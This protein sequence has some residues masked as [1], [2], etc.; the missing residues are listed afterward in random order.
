MVL[1]EISGR[2]RDW[3]GTLTILDGR[4][5]AMRVRVRIEVASID[6]GSEA[7]DAQIRSAEFFDVE[8]HPTAVF[9][10]NVIEPLGGGRFVVRGR[11]SLCGAE[12]DITLEVQEIPAAS[13]AVGSGTRAFAV[14]AAI[15]RREFG[16]RWN[17]DQDVGGVVVADRVLLSGRIEAR[18]AAA[19]VRPGLRAY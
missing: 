3:D 8:R 9:E 4:L 12:R 6:T 15:D 2:F 5:G 14:E 7:R 11:L 17:Q 18:A 13:A 10:G 19:A 16:L 1:H